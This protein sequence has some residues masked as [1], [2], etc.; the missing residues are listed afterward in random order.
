M[1]GHGRRGGAAIILLYP[2]WYLLWR[3]PRSSPRPMPHVVFVA[4]YVVMTC[5]YLW[6]KFR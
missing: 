1:W 6:K 5:A 2:V 3:A 4:L